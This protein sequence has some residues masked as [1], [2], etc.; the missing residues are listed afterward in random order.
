MSNSSDSEQSDGGKGGLSSDEEE[1]E[2]RN[3]DRGTRAAAG[4]G[5]SVSARSAGPS[6]MAAGQAALANFTIAFRGGDPPRQHQVV[7]NMQDEEKLLT[8]V[9]S[10]DPNVRDAIT[11]G[12]LHQL[13]V[14]VSQA[15]AG[16]Q[17]RARESDA[18]IQGAIKAAKGRPAQSPNGVGQSSNSIAIV[19]VHVR[20]GAG[21]FNQGKLVTSKPKVGQTVNFLT[22]GDIFDCSGELGAAM[23]VMKHDHPAL[24]KGA[25]DACRMQTEDCLRMALA[26]ALNR[27]PLRSA[28]AACSLPPVL[29]PSLRRLRTKSRSR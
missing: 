7:V 8:A 22:L 15:A 9:A 28:L 5:S 24:F 13:L 25:V 26:A 27:V 19:E 1:D 17:K 4:G 11:V 12:V 3:G 2:D 21:V 29:T 10:A 23:G 6:A 20:Y 14:V 16:A 18:S